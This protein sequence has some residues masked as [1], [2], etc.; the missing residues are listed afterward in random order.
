MDPQEFNEQQ[1]VRYEKL[2]ALREAGIDP[3][4]PRTARTHLSQTAINDFEAHEAQSE[5]SPAPLP[6]ITVG[7]RVVAVRVMGKASFAHIEDTAGRLQL[8]LKQDELGPESYDHFKKLV[9]LGDFIEAQGTMF[10]TKM[11]E[12]TLAVS[13]W[14]IV[15]K[16]LN[17]PPDKWHGL[18]DTDQRYRQRYA[19]LLANE[20]VRRLFIQRSRI[21]SAIRRFL[22]ARNFLEVETPILQP[23]YG[24]A[25]AEPFVTHHNWAKR[26]LY[27]RISDELYLK[28]LLVGGLERVFE[29]GKD[30]R[31]EGVS[32]KHSPEFTMLEAY[33]AF[34]DYHDMMELAE[35]C[36]HSVAVEVLG[37]PIIVRQ[38]VEINLT[39]PWR[40]LN[41]REAIHQNTGIDLDV[42]TTLPPLQDRIK[43]LG[44]KVEFK[45]T[46]GKQ[47][48]ELFG[49]YVEPTLIQPTFLIDY[50]LE[51]SPLAKRTPGNPM[52][53]E[54]F[55]GFIGG[56]EAMNA[57]TELNDPLD[58][59]E[60]FLAMAKDFAAGD[61]EAHPLDE[62]YIN[63]LM[64]AIPPTGGIGWGIDR[65]VMILLDQPAIREVI[66]FPQ[67]RAT[68]PA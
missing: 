25:A 45:P 10:R 9:D 16:A 12:A 26:D 28:R 39:P 2:L 43:Q 65:M 29:I 5:R 67:L 66:L 53:T 11:G 55:E 22:E 59:R 24:G 1:Q 20:N 63:A 7:G 38:G 8:F 37:G 54:R 19:D 50:P 62:D 57:F 48:D 32:V 46:W 68:T 3:Y 13:N 40:R 4:P 27:L 51:L 14:Q 35:S 47:V 34:A 60:R 21:V 64:Y 6:T 49:E 33:Q 36:W 17:P 56:M 15:S 61:T 41:F 44:L 42:D 52:W 18:A 31:N 58:Q 30:F 23:L